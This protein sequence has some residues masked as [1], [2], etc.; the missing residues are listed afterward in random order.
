MRAQLESYR[1]VAAAWRLDH[2]RAMACRDLEDWLDFGLALLDTIRRIDRRHRERVS[3]GR[4]A[5]RRADAEDVSRLYEIWYAPCDHLLGM[6]DVFEGEGY[7]VE[8]AGRFRDACRASHIPGLEPETL[9]AA[10][11]QFEQGGGRPVREVM[12]EIRRRALGQ[13]VDP[14]PGTPR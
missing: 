2:Q 3:A 6:I 13:G 7:R 11:E 1:D 4:V 12:D 9:Q 5:F 8:N 10:A 14:A